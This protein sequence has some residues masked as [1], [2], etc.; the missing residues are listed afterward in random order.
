MGPLAEKLRAGSRYMH[1]QLL[2]EGQDCRR[3]SPAAC[4]R[5]ARLIINII[6][7]DCSLQK[8][9]LHVFDTQASG[10]CLIDP[11]GF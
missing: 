4:D 3:L 6:I 2:T 11:D 7:I 8:T 5:L 9:I 1:M 10:H